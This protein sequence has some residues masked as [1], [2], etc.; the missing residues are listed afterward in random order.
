M[1]YDDI[2]IIGKGVVRILIAMR[3]KM[4]GPLLRQSNA[5]IAVSAFNAETLSPLAER[6]EAMTNQ[7]RPRVNPV[8]SRSFP[9]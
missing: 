8:E 6:M 2:Q 5:A 9:L 3:R 4:R 1:C 7:T